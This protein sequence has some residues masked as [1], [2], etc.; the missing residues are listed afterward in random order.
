MK[1]SKKQPE[2]VDDDAPDKDGWVRSSQALA[3]HLDVHRNSITGWRKQ[4][5]DAPARHLDGRKENLPAWKEF[6]QRNGLGRKGD[7]VQ[8]IEELRRLKME[9]E[10]KLLELKIAKEEGRTRDVE[11]VKALLMKI[12]S[13]QKRVLHQ[14]LVNE[15]SGRVTGKSAAEIRVVGKKLF[16]Q[17]CVVFSDEQAGFLDA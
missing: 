15:L 10:T 12:A 7:E 9:K 8:G 17:L 6:V 4:F 16:N 2:P 5:P 3:R 11:D 14:V 1:R 13:R